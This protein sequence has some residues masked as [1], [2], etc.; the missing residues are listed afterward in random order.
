MKNNYDKNSK[1]SANLRK[2]CKL[3]LSTIFHYK[4]KLNVSFA[5]SI[6]HET[7]ISAAKC[8]IPE[9][10][11]CSS[12]LTLINIWWSIVNAKTHFCAN[13]LAH[14]IIPGDNKTKFLK[15][16]ADW[17]EMWC[18]SD[19]LFACAIKCLMPLLLL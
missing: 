4:N 7:T 3:S 10:K 14:A 17:L 1:L 18:R 6:F 12:F 15:A 19:P 13:P 2:A 9:K 11:D 16:F 8:Y 5:L